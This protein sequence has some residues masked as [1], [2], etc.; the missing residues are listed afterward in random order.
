MGRNRNQLYPHGSAGDT[1]SRT[2]ILY[3]DIAPGAEEDASITTT[4][5]ETF[6]NPDLLPAGVTPAPTITCE[7]NHWGLDGAYMLVE[8]EP[9]AFW[10]TE[11]SGDDCSFQ[12]KPV[13]TID[14]DQQYSSVGITLV[15]DSASDEFCNSVNIKWYQ[16]ETQ[17]A[18]ADFTPNSSTYFCQ[19]QVESYNKVVI[20]INS[21][22]LPGRRA[23]LEHIIF[24]IFRYFTMGELRSASIVNE[25]NLITT[26]LPISTMKWTLDSDDDV[27]F[28]FQLKQP[29]EV[30]NNDSLIGVYYIDAYSRSA[31]TVYDIECYDALGVLDETPFDGGVYSSKSAM[32]LLTEILDG[33][34]SIEYGEG[35][36]DTTLTG[37]LQASSKREAIQQVLFAWGV[38]ASTDGRES[39]YVFN[40]PTDA[41]IVSPNRT[42]TG[43]TVETS[44]IVTKVNVTAHTYTQSDS[45]SIEVAGVKYSDTT[46]VYSVSNPNVTATDKQNVV[47]ISG[48]TLVSPAIGQAVAQR[49]YDYYLNRN[50]N[51]AKI[52]WNGER[53]GDYLTMP[54][55]WNSTNTGHL[56]KMEI[57]LSNTVAASCETIGV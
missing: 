26:E 30:R 4:T 19:Q 45:G 50:T 18:S 22:N 55:A 17:K 32:A 6:A 40:L 3:K 16:G 41:E 44:A 34:F 1:V 25:M 53:L 24:G 52:V 39:I 12:N 7:L 49:V 36:T 56:A 42:Y 43:V 11:L 48:A 33:D 2:T 46:S 47:E 54:N 21:T 20:T 23:K 28:M 31:A 51:K 37:I 38:C 9:V 35:V 10:S 57:K 27:D 14:F 8:N 5:S 15:F 13:I 29:V